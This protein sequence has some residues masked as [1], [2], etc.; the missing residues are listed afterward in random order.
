MKRIAAYS[1]ALVGVTAALLWAWVAQRAVRTI[2]DLLMKNEALQ[3]A[4]AELTREDQIGYAKVLGQEVRNGEL[5]T[6][7]RFVE[8]ALGEPD[9][10]VQERE[11]AVPGDAIFFDALVVKFSSELVMDGEERALYLWRRLFSERMRPEEG[12]PLDDPGQAPERYKDWLA[13][14][15]LEHRRLFWTEIWELANA[16]DRLSAQG[17]ASIYGNAVYFRMKPGKVYLFKIGS[18]GQISPEV[19]DDI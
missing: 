10:V 16:P 4:I 17:I 12:L 7:V 2:E 11:Y 8:T 5:Y 18:N 13:R 15:P 19:V 9:R 1:L 3:E 6:R 14:L